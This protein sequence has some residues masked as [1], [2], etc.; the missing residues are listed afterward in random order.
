MTVSVAQQLLEITGRDMLTPPTVLQDEI[1]T[2]MQLCG[3]T[4]LMRD[5]SPQYVNTGEIDA[6]VRKG[7]H[8]YAR[9]RKGLRASL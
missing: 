1:K 5:A 6:L 9:E 3:L 2:A 8:P 7:S 4:D